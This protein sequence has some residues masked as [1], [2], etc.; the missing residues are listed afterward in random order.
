MVVR[1]LGVKLTPST[2][3]LVSPCYKSLN[4]QHGSLFSPKY[5]LAKPRSRSYF[6]EQRNNERSMIEN[7]HQGRSHVQGRIMFSR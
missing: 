3:F 6:S 7:L 4:V 2:P 5:A 1:I